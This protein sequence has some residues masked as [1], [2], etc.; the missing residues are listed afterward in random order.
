[1]T[2]PVQRMVRMQLVADGDDGAIV[3]LLKALLKQLLR[4]YGVRCS[5]VVMEPAAAEETGSTPR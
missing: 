3:R 1:M 4:R 2:A 5:L